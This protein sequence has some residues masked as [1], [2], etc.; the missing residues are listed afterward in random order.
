MSKNV[1]QPILKHSK[2]IQSKPN[3]PMK[4]IR[5]L[6]SL[7]VLLLIQSFSYGQN[8]S[9]T[10]D[11]VGNTNPTL[12]GYVGN[13]A[14]SMWVAPEGIVYTS[15]M[16]D[17]KGRNIGIYQNGAAIGSM[18]G[19]NQGQGCA[20]AGDA[21]SLYVALQDNPGKVGRY[22][23][24]SKARDLIIPVS[25]G[26][27]D[28]ITGIAAYNGEIYVSDFP[29]NRIQVYST[30][31]VFKRG[32]SVTGPGA[33]AVE[34]GGANIWVAQQSTGT[35]RR[36][37]SAGTAGTVFAMAATSRP[38]AL[39]V[40]SQGQLWVGDQGPD[41]NI[42]IYTNLTGTPSLSGT[43]GV[44]GGYLSTSGGLM[45]QTGA[46]RFTRIAGIGSDNSGNV[47]VLNN[48]WGGTWDL[49]RNGV[50][51]LHCY[52]SAGSLAWTLQ[53]LN[54]EG[55]AAPDSGTDGAN[56]YT[57]A[58]ILSGS[59][60]AGL[61]ANTVNPFRYPFDPRINA[62]YAD[63]GMHFGH[64]ASVGG[65]R[66]LAASGQNPDAFFTYYFNAATDGYV[67][68]PGQAYSV[69][70][71][72]RV[73][74]GFC[75]DS[76]GNV[77]TSLD[78]SNAI[79][80][81]P[82]T[83]FAANG[84]PIW[85][86]AVSTPTPASVARLN[87]IEYL[88]ESDTM[89]L[90]GGSEDWT[91]LGNRIE[92]YQGWG[93]GNRVP[94]AV[95][96]LN[97]AQAKSMSA[98]GS[99]LFVGYYAVPNVDVFDLATGGFV[100]TLVSNNNVFVGNDTDSMYGVK[101]YKKSNGE[102]M[103]CKDD[104]NTNKVVIYRWDPNAETVGF[105]VANAVNPNGHALVQATS[106]AN[107][108]QTDLATFAANVAA[109]YSS[110]MGGVVDFDGAGEALDSSPAMIAYYGTNK[111]L[112][113]GVTANSSLGISPLAPPSGTS[114]ATNCLSAPDANPNLG[115]ITF[116]MGAINNGVAN[117]KVTAF[118]FTYL[119]QTALNGIAVTVTATFS[120]N[121][122]SVVNRT[123]NRNTASPAQD[124]FFAFVA[125]GGKSIKSVALVSNTSRADTTHIDDVGFITSAVASM[126]A[127]NV[128]NPNGHTLV[129]GT[130][131]ANA[132]QTNS[133]TF[134]SNV[135]AAFSANMG[136]VV[137]FDAAG[138]GLGSGPA[139]IANYGGGKSLNVGL[140]AG[141]ALDIS[142][143]APP[144]GPTGSVNCLAAPNADPNL[145]DLIFTMGSVTGGAAN[146]KVT[147]FA[148]TY[149]TQTA[150]NGISITVTAT[151]SDNSTS[152]VTRTVNRDTNN[153]TL[154]TFFAFVAPGGKSI[155]SVA[156][157]SSTNRGGT[158]R[159]DDVG[160]ITASVP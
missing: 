33:I 98:A 156:L 12:A 84:A 140:N 100:M 7:A 95:I 88:P 59:G 76:A 65:K 144:S 50:T 54:F 57:G 10:T 120:D 91:L 55:N 137:N 68:I 64:L 121:S 154:D 19:T 106:A 52:N 63:R 134:S 102:Y 40:N 49:G 67:A 158:T 112:T 148:F 18:G 109:A 153:P 114:G 92:V 41:M 149:L 104:Y 101:A 25:A 28:A 23:R 99:Y 8:T 53:A 155:K 143:L 66:I 20:I 125:P 36:F 3:Q 56:L 6:V 46:K 126:Q 9:Y 27:G 111:S 122:T 96:T 5:T 159:V 39:H 71:Y 13:C 135:A 77:W 119:T 90:G 38:S 11:W 93:G 31:G 115:D 107:P 146:E 116:T 42:K 80:K 34:N 160:F 157:V 147:A 118:S 61:L 108:N 69:A 17:E 24:T 128:I 127:T 139:L 1:I 2:L 75:L 110:H 51:D 94:N 29:G 151:F 89:I 105:G 86:A 136:G 35:L 133:A 22:N 48:P 130:S 85:G 37:S 150:L 58:L 142:P 113:I 152:V 141:C 16:W 72:G 14:R 145:G 62:A 78:K 103:I 138:G 70:T 47:Y 83:G 79:Q 123:I 21:T 124:T 74:N 81:Y 117:E 45:G 129:Q 131:V 4:K 43:Y 15:S 60:G 97:R 26:T 32:W 73:R 82:L 44:T 132:N 30:A 87:R